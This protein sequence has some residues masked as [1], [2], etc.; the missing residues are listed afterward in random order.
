V[1]DRL[2]VGP[3]QRA[4]RVRAADRVDCPRRR[5]GR[6]PDRCLQVD[7]DRASDSPP[8]VAKLAVWY[9]GAA[10]L[11]RHSV[12]RVPL[13]GLVMALAQA[14][15]VLEVPKAS[16]L[17]RMRWPVPGAEASRPVAVAA[18]SRALADSVAPAVVG[19][20][21]AGAEEVFSWS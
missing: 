11:P 21:A 7:S 17:T 10:L 8:L 13:A 12:R 3:A 2:R 1:A 4:E 6:L 18:G 5:S 19:S 15:T 16:E 9:A 14:S 20:A